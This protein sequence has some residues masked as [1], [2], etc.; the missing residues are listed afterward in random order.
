[1]PT[2]KERVVEVELQE[3]F[4]YV[5]FF[6][7]YFTFYSFFPNVIKDELTTILC[8]QTTMSTAIVEN[9]TWYHRVVH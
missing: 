2:G 4:F 3:S 1:M 6:M 8:K 5:K 9:A 7:G